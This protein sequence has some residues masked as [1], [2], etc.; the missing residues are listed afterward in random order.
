MRSYVVQPGDSPAKIAGRH[1]GCPKC[2][3][4]LVRANPH[5]PTLV[6]PNGFATFK[7]MRVGEKLNLPDKWASPRFDTFPSTYFAALPHADGVT[8]SKLHPAVV[9]G[10]LGDYSTLDLAATK[11]DS[12]PSLSDTE[13]ADTAIEA[14]DALSK[15]V[16]EVIP[17]SNGVAIGSALDTQALAFDA[18]TR[19]TGMQAAL[20]VGSAVVAARTQI[21]SSLAVGLD[22]AHAALS[23]FYASPPPVVTP[24]PSI[25]VTTAVPAAV[26]AILSLDP[27]VAQNAAMVC[28]AQTIMGISPDG[29]YGDT[30]SA[31][32]RKIAP[33]APPA[34]NPR[35]AWWAPTGSKNCPGATPS[36]P[37]NTTPLPPGPTPLPSLP[38]PV[39]PVSAPPNGGLGMAGVTGLALL[40]AGAVGGAIYLAMNHSPRRAARRY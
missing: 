5:K 4:D 15:S 6:A 17:S 33:G 35:P 22:K 18:R 21:Q 25:P 16:Q 36:P 13:F 37:R 32:A 40:G 20:A 28:A 38:T 8:V 27:C 31:A 3:R 9:A 12:L 23:S 7:T 39:P 19:A 30:T 2:A 14:A 29:K 26:Q 1:A 24:V 11:I 34:C 10:V